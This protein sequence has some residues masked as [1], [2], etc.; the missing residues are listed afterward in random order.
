[1]PTWLQP[2]PG[3][4]SITPMHSAR[5]HKSGHKVT[6]SSPGLTP[7]ALG[8][9]A[10]SFQHHCLHHEHT[11]SCGQTSHLPENSSPPK[12]ATSK[13]AAGMGL[14]AWL[15][16]TVWQ[17]QSCSEGCLT[18]EQAGCCWASTGHTPGPH[19]SSLCGCSNCDLNQGQRSQ[20]L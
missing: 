11:P 5:S 13:G 14:G 17:G 20:A 8:S 15:A 1:M 4:L 9:W 18:A 16:F 10:G 3:R 6:V 19:S 12:R 2:S 7:P